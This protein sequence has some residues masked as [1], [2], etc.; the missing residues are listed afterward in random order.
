[1]G[2]NKEEDKNRLH[3]VTVYDWDTDEPCYLVTNIEDMKA[4]QVE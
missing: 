1:M 2:D 4:K 3:V